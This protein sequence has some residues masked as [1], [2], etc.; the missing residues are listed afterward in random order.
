M[1]YVLLTYIFY[2][3]LNLLTFLKKKNSLSTPLLKE[4]GGS[5][6][7]FKRVL[8]IQTAKIG[9]MICSAP[10]FREIKKKYPHLHLTVMQSPVTAELLK[11]N[12]YVDEVIE[13]EGRKKDAD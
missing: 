5:S 9:D 4:G 6:G 12:P 7:K 13:D 1:I 3:F 2:P 8:V 10:I 11:Y